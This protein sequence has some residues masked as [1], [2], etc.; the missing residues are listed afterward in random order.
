MNLFIVG[1]TP[2]SPDGS[3]YLHFHTQSP[4]RL[5]HGKQAYKLPAPQF[6]LRILISKLLYK[7]GTKEPG[8]QYNNKK[9]FNI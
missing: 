6:D 5:R 8:K 4:P 7:L 1:T 3:S 9:T 2:R